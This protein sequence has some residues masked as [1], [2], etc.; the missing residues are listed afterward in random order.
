MGEAHL[1]A[2]FGWL[3]GSEAL[4]QQIDSL[5]AP[6]RAGNV[7]YWQRRFT[8]SSRRDFAIVEGNTHLGNCGLCNLDEA[9]RKAEL[10]IYLGE[11][12][13][14][15]VG[16]AAV[17]ELLR[18]AFEELRLN[19]VY[20]RVVADNPRALEFYRRLGF[21]EEGRFRQD[22]RHGDAFVDS[23]WLAILAGDY[24]AGAR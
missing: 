19:R 13:G 1:D 6:T 3:S 18:L 16:S 9:R 15:G 24:F 14:G 2:T 17:R 22:T 23:I 12:R 4:R 21:K 7:A 10:W 11:R 8:D 5:A 20:L